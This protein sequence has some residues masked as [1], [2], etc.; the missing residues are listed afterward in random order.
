MM[1]NRLPGDAS[2]RRGLSY[3]PVVVLLM[4]GVGVRVYCPTVGMSKA[5][6][7]DSWHGEGTEI[8]Q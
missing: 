4:A 3:G 1:T 2:Q 8:R 5:L 6:K 7:S